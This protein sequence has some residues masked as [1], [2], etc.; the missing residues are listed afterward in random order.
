MWVRVE[1][2]CHSHQKLSSLQQLLT[3]LANATNIN[4]L[5]IYF[6]PAT[7]PEEM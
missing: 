5:F 1:R 7:Q 2:I 6:R 4:L 3:P